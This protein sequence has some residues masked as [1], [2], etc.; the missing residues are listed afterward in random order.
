[1][2]IFS[3][4][5][6]IATDAVAEGSRSMAMNIDYVILMILVGLFFY[7]LRGTLPVAYGLCEIAAGIA[8][9]V[10]TFN[11]PPMPSILLRYRT[12]FEQSLPTT[13]S[14]LGGVYVMV[15]GLDNVQRGLNPTWKRRWRIIF[16]QR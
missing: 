15:R 3:K 12:E 5:H 1:V 8:V 13:M 2:L 6:R 9:I 7:W 16:P 4:R 14:L 10:I 11:Y